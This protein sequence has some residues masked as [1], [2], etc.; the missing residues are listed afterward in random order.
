LAAHLL[1][2]GRLVL[3]GG[4][5]TYDEGLVAD[6]ADDY[7]GVVIFLAVRSARDGFV[8]GGGEG[9]AFGWALGEVGGEL[10]GDVGHSSDGDA[11][12]VGCGALPARE[13]ADSGALIVELDGE[14]YAAAEDTVSGGFV[15]PGTFRLCM[16]RGWRE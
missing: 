3:D 16:T 5:Y 14:S 10:F 7:F 1:R 6:T 12:F 8:A 11:E 9:R 15:E 2:H 13:S 4:A